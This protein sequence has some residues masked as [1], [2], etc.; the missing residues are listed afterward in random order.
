M[1]RPLL[2]TLTILGAVLGLI[3]GT[4]VFAALTDT[5]D[6]GLNQVA[7]PALDGSADLQLGTEIGGVCTFEENL[8]TPWFDYGP[9]VEPG[10]YDTVYVCLRNVGSQ[11][12]AVTAGVVDLHDLE[13]DCTG[14][15]SD[16]DLTCGADAPGEL[17][18]SLVTWL[19]QVECG[20]NG[21]VV[22]GS[23]TPGGSL[24]TLAATPVT[25]LPLGPDEAVCYS[26]RIERN[27]AT[28]ETLQAQQSDVVTWRYR[29]TAQA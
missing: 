19:E 28:P 15:E 12:V 16:F 26:V 10:F 24:T 21:V 11:T 23:A 13:V 6:S 2:L 27:D 22:P 5:A 25:I 4:G 14:D 8:T 17:A 29:F 20:T 9:N 1:R 18:P 7:S 3:A